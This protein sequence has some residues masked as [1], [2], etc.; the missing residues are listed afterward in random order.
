MADPC[1]WSGTD[2]G[3][4]SLTPF[5]KAEN[6]ITTRVTGISMSGLD[7]DVEAIYSV[8]GTS[9]LKLNPQDIAEVELTLKAVKPD[10]SQAVLGGIGTVTNAT[11]YP[12]NAARIKHRVA[13]VFEESSATNVGAKL[14]F[15]WTNA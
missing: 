12:G 2:V 1:L 4:V 8:G 6:T 5:A 14:R 10:A 11:V 15:V 13:V 9:C 3:K 7:R